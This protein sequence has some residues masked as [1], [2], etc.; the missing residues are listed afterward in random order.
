[1]SPPNETSAEIEGMLA[2]RKARVSLPETKSA[3]VLATKFHNS[4]QLMKSVL[5]LRTG[6]EPT[7]KKKFCQVAFLFSWLRRDPPKTPLF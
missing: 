1:V 5:S 7:E 3:L 6:L 4:F 2:A